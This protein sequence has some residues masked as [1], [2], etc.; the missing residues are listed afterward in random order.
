[1]PNIEMKAVYRDLDSARKIIKDLNSQFLWKD[2]QVDTYF[3]TRAGKL[4]L[5]Q[6]QLNGS[7]LLPYFKTDD[8]GL[9]RS[10]YVRLPTQ[11]PELL[12]SLLDQLLG[13][14]MV[15]RKIGE[16]YLIENVRVHLDQVDGLGNFLEFEAVFTEESAEVQNRE[17]RKVEKLMQQF[18]ISPSDLFDG[19]YPE[20]L[21][22]KA[23]LQNT[24]SI[25]L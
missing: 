25:E 20:L 8:D 12:C 19:S 4:K 21:S 18:L 3:F 6:S 7:E 16:V 1:M 5:R 17:K 14:K 13:T 24:K 9:K 11:E 23:S 2:S 15:V 10:D 22:A